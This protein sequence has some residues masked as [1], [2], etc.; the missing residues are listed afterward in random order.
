MTQHTL[1]AGEV[2]D[3]NE[4]AAMLRRSRWSVYRLVDS[5]ELSAFRDGNR[6]RI[7][8]SSVQEFLDN[9]PRVQPAS[10]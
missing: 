1:K 8:L 2:L 3:V 5:G 9:L 4:A 6:L 10:A 7:P